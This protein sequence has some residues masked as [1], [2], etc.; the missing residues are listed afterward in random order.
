MASTRQCSKCGVDLLETGASTCS[1]CGA[2]IGRAGTAKW[3][4]ALVQITLSTTFMLVFRFPKF[5]IAI[6]AALIVAGTALSGFVKPK[7][8]AQK[9]ASQRPLSHPALFRVLCLGIAICGL[10]FVS[11]LLFGFVGFM[12]S[13]NRYQQYEGVSFHRSEFHVARTYFKR[14][15]RGGVDAYAKGT[16]EDQPEWMSL[17]PYLDFVPRS[18][19]EVDSSVPLGTTIPIYYFPA[20]KGRARVQVVGELP[21]AEEGHRDA[22]NALSYGLAGLAISGG[23]LFVM[24]RLLNFCYRKNESAFAATA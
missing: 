3:V 1:A 23:L 20:L 8:T 4:I 10:A 21:P 16:V 12:N 7:T 9:S 14:V 18:Q 6:F 19:A 11:S 24:L 5:V 13:W 15:G 22:M 2:K 17:R